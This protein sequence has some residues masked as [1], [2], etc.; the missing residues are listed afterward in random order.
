MYDVVALGELVI[1]FTP[2]KLEKDEAPT[3]T[4]N[5]GGAPANVLACASK[6]GIKTAMLSKI[7]DDS[8][9]NF[10]V[11]ALKD[12]EVDTKGVVLSKYVDTSLAFVHLGDD[13]DRSFSF[14]RTKGADKLI[15]PDD[16]DFSLIEQSKIFHFGSL[17]L[18]DEP[19]RATTI[20]AAIFAKTKGKILS[21]DVNWRGSL[22]SDKNTGLLQIK[23]A[24]KYPHIVK[25]SSEELLMIAGGNDITKGMSNVMKYFPNIQILTVTMGKEGAYVANKSEIRHA[26][27]LQTVK[28]I[29]TTGAG[30]CF[31]G[32]F[33]Y[34]IIKSVQS[35]TDIPMDTLEKFALFANCA[36]A[37][38]VTKNGAI[39]SMPTIEEIKKLIL[40]D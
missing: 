30:D 24:I 37:I 29:D 32:A 27:A 17:T 1:D 13:G 28:A 8:F 15:T 34:C 14:Y 18:T 26:P 38:C 11:N 25:M 2:I 40:K 5:A 35:F 7:S 9:G 23:N 19:S 12:I 39:P 21:F 10:L 6:L 22:W 33:L 31:M 20:E 16:I 4:Q 3:F 36:A